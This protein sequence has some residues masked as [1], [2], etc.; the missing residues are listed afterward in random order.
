[1]TWR[2]YSKGRLYGA[3]ESTVVYFDSYSGDTH[4]LS[5]FAGYV[6]QLLCDK[7]LTTEELVNQISH[8]IDSEEIPDLQKVVINILEELVLLDILQ[9][10]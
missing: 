6:M 3:N 2:V 7:P 5:D 10:D 9:R 4:L 8:S 1:M